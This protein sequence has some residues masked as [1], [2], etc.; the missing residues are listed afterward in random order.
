MDK[1]AVKPVGWQNIGTYKVEG[2]YCPN[3]FFTIPDKWSESAFGS[4]PSTEVYAAI[5]SHSLIPILT[6]DQGSVSLSS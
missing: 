2:L 3:L 1:P 6:Y 5:A 4:L